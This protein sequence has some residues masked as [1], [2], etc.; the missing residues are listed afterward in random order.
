MKSQAHVVPARAIHIR[1]IARL[2]READRN[3]VAA[4][5]RDP[6]GALTLSLRKSKRAW[7]II[8]DGQPIGMFGV[9]DV[10]ILAEVGSP[11]MLGTPEIERH[12]MTFLRN[13]PYWVGQLLEGYTVLRNCVDDRN[14]LSIRWLKWLGF[15]VGERVVFKGHLFR[16]FEMRSTEDV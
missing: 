9:G 12:V 1:R 7:T 8:A 16:M 13:C 3:E 11:W 6:F 15:E 2:M 5:G 4:L 10:N 14:R